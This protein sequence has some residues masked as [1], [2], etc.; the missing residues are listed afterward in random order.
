VGHHSRHGWFGGG[1]WSEHADHPAVR[2]FLIR[3]TPEQRTAIGVRAHGD[4][5]RCEDTLTGVA[6][7]YPG[8]DLAPYASIPEG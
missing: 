8:L 3:A 4:P 1:P 2:R 6:A 7:R 5:F